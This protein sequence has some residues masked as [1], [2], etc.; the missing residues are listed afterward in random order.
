VKFLPPLLNPSWAAVALAVVCVIASYSQP[1]HAAG[2]LDEIVDKAQAAFD[3]TKSM[4]SDFLQVF[5]S[6]G[7]GKTA[8]YHGS[9]F[10]L[11][12][13]KMLWKYTEPKGRML[14][15]DGADL[16][17]YDPEDNVAYHDQIKGYLHE[18]SPA[19]FLAG[20]K[21]LRELFTID[22]VEPAKTDKLDNVVRL[23]LTPKSPQLG[24]KGLLLIADGTTY[25]IVELM[26]VD[27]L[28][29]RNKITFLNAERGVEIAPSI[30]K[31]TPPEGTPVRPMQKLPDSG[32]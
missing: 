32:Q 24:V 21:T 20:E 22:L 18:K 15:S 23:K 4:K 29:N 2:K 30:F 9:V 11:K 25:N 7:F 12:P 26:M 28:G 8:E 6:K 3:K 10:I 1:S 17:L 31:F 13:S 19:L 27:H 16:W 5:E 14:L